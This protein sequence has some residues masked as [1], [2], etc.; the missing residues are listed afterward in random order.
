MGRAEGED[1]VDRAV[2]V[3]GH[4]EHLARDDAPHRMGDDEDG[5][6]EGQMGIDAGSGLLVD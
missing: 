4:G 3:V 1:G 2:E 5:L 6:R